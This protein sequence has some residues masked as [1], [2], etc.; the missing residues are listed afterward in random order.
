MKLKNGTRILVTTITLV[1]S[2]GL[3]FTS[4][5]SASQKYDED[6][7]STYE[8]TGGL[9]TRSSLVSKGKDIRVS[10]APTSGTRG[11]S[12]GIRLQKF[13]PNEGKNG[14]WKYVRNE[15]FVDSSLGG[16]VVFK[17]VKKAKFRLY[18]RNYTHT[19]MGSTGHGT[20]WTGGILVEFE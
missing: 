13:Y 5:V 19:A 4:S 18:L 8:M 20:K 1:L 16:S 3:F 7:E 12:M 10:I 15:K 17:N 6:Y 11:C 14:K 2:L 9:Y